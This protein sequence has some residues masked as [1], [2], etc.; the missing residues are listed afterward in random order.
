VPYA[1]NN[2]QILPESPIADANADSNASSRVRQRAEKASAFDI[3][4]SVMLFDLR[5]LLHLR[6][7][8]SGV[9]VSLRVG[10]REPATAQLDSTQQEN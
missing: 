3:R 5:A 10:M 1:T 6:I 2:P 9:G 4:W 7:G 8:G